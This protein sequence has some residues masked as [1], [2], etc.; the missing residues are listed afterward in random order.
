MLDLEVQKEKFKNHV[1]IFTDYGNIKILDFKNPENN[2]Y[3]I[4][5]LFEEDYYRLHIS[6]DLGQLIATNYNNMTFKKFTDFVNNKDYFMSKI[7]CHDRP[8]WYY[9]QNIAEKQL[10]EYFDDYSVFDSEEDI[11]ERN[12]AIDDALNDILNC[13]DEDK[14]LS[15]EG[16]ELFGKYI[17]DSYDVCV[18]AQDLGKTETGIIDLYL[19]AFRLATEQ[20]DAANN[21]ISKSKVK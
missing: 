4:R 5:F 21:S 17:P 19:L 15:D 16:F 6:G 1:A 3:H 8:I 14:G 7:D 18:L 12:N 10:K 9:D 13:L 20:L 2:Y 11:D